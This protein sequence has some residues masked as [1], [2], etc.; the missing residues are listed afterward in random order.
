MWWFSPEAIENWERDRFQ[1]E[2]R[3]AR[4]A[5]S[6][7]NSPSWSQRFAEL[8]AQ[9]NPDGWRWAPGTTV[10]VHD[11]VWQSPTQIAEWALQ[12]LSRSWDANKFFDDPSH[13]WVFDN[14]VSNFMN[15]SDAALI[16]L[17]QIIAKKISFNGNPSTLK[18]SVQD[19]ALVCQG[20]TL[21]N[22]SDQRARIESNNRMPL[23]EL[24]DD[25]VQKLESVWLKRAGWMKM[26]SPEGKSLNFWA[27]NNTYTIDIHYIDTGNRDSEKWYE[28]ILNQNVQW[29]K[30]T[31][32]RFMESWSRGQFGELLDASWVPRKIY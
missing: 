29:Q 5:Q 19:G 3:R 14:V 7:I 12:D 18:V 13:K 22:I 17:K 1:A 31:T 26:L 2:L 23:S 8:Y 10:S 15:I 4:D 28:V 25:V 16:Q 9:A 32:L 30:V 21:R 6:A 11:S 27:N 20:I 24:P